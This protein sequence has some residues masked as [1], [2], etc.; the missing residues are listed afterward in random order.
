M[1]FGGV[2]ALYHVPT[3]LRV[4]TAYNYQFVCVQ[5]PQGGSLLVPLYYHLLE[6]MT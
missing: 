1:I 4:Y 3:T 5:G 6:Q 2:S